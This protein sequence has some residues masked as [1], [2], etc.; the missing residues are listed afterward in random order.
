[1]SEFEESHWEER[2]CLEEHGS[3]YPSISEELADRGM[4]IHDFI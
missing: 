4:N 2:E 3:E 1:M